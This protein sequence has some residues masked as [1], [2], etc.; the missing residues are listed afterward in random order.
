MKKPMNLLMNLKISDWIYN[1]HS[2]MSIFFDIYL[3][4]INIY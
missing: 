2:D 1:R 4:T 3:T